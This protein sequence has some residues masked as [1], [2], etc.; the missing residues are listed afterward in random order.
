MNPLDTVNEVFAKN[1]A[2]QA[3]L[4]RVVTLVSWA[5]VALYLVWLINRGSTPSFPLVI[6]VMVLM[7]FGRVFGSH[8]S[9][10]GSRIPQD[11][12]SHHRGTL[13]A[14]GRCGCC[15]Y[16]LLELAPANDGCVECPECSAAWHPSRV[17]F[18]GSTSKVDEGNRLIK[19]LAT[20]NRGLGLFA[21]DRNVLL[22][23]PVTWPPGLFNKDFPARFRK[24][25][26]DRLT[27]RTSRHRTPALTALGCVWLASILSIPF[28]DDPRDSLFVIVTVIFSLIAAGIGY[29]IIRA[30]LP[31]KHV[32]T[33]CLDLCCCPECK[34][35]LDPTQSAFDART[36]CKQC[37]RAWLTADLGTPPPDP[38]ATTNPCP[39]CG[40]NAVGPLLCPECGGPVPK[41][42]L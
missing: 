1:H 9:K 4:Q 21:D 16:S 3:A 11:A 32:R 41:V 34:S 5:C 6:F 31:Q 40:Y 38:A 42:T 35:L 13:L 37:G 10:P 26:T 8:G 28:W 18:M 30:H 22:T 7:A 19:L 23:D 12:F 20:G 33:A 24:P 15:G 14:T 27:E 25:L 36:V 2:T 39:S 17:I 29:L